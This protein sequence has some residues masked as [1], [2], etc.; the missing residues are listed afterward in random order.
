VIRQLYISLYLF[1]YRHNVPSALVVTAHYIID[2][3]LSFLTVDI[4]LV[5][6]KA[7]ESFVVCVWHFSLTTSTDSQQHTANVVDTAAYLEGPAKE[8][9]WAG[10]TV[11]RLTLG[12]GTTHS[13]RLQ[14]CFLGAGLYNVNALRVSAGGVDDA[15]LVLQRSGSAAPIVVHQAAPTNRAV[16]AALLA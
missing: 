4:T 12:A 7:E 5:I 8:F 13:T 16:P 10:P 2:Y 9:A 1:T 3:L 6:S 14:A 15:E 11:Q